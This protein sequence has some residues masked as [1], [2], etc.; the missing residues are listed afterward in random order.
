[1][2]GGNAVRPPPPP[3]SPCGHCPEYPT[4]F[5]ADAPIKKIKDTQYI[6]IFFALIN[7]F[8]DKIFS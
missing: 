7:F 5:I 6:N 8:V 1:M 2:G 4:L 3:P